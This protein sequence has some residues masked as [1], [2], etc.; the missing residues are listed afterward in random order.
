MRERVLN[1]WCLAYTLGHVAPTLEG[2]GA[3]GDGVGVGGVWPANLISHAPPQD[4]RAMDENVHG[5][6][7]PKVVFGLAVLYPPCQHKQLYIL[8]IH[9]LHLCEANNNQSHQACRPCDPPIR[10]STVNSNPSEHI[11]NV[12]KSYTAACIS[13]EE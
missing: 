12:I 9:I 13:H 10:E 5:D 1:H 8:A 2:G 3:E 4:S 6:M 11:V 7:E